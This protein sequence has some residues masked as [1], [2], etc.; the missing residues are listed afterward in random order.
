MHF[1]D[2]DEKMRDF[3]KLTKDEFLKS[4]SYLSEQ[5]YD[6]TKR[7]VDNGKILEI[8]LIGTDSW[9]R[10]VYKGKDGTLYKDV[11]LGYGNNLRTSLHTS[12]GNSFDGEPFMPLDENV[13]VKSFHNKGEGYPSID[14]IHEKGKGYFVNNPIIP[15]MSIHNALKLMSFPYRKENAVDCLRHR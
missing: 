6:E 15:S 1:I 12:A 4:Y 13:I 11:N 14:R 2:D 10:L 8:T 7:K 5:D 9:D 3:F